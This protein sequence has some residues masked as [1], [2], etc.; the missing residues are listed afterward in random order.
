MA[1]LI[2]LVD[3]DF[4]SGKGVDVDFVVWSGANSVGAFDAFS[5]DTVSLCSVMINDMCERE[6]QVI[7]CLYP[8]STCI[9][10]IL[11]N[12]VPTTNK[13]R[14]RSGGG[15]HIGNVKFILSNDSDII[16][17]KEDIMIRRKRPFPNQLAR[18]DSMMESFDDRAR[19]TVI[20][21]VNEDIA[22]GRFID[23][24]A[25]PHAV[26]VGGEVFQC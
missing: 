22:G 23:V 11:E 12:S 13:R 3:E 1:C 19:S 26:G 20:D 25:V 24:K 9:H 15:T 10:V 17:L 18:P 2:S 16:R 21:G 4:T 6:T 14:K 8:Q 5:N 7:H